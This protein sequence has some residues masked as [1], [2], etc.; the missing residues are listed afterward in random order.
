MNIS[1]PSPVSTTQRARHLTGPPT[2]YA[3]TAGVMG[4]RP[5][6]LSRI[7]ELSK[8]H[9]HVSNAESWLEI[10]WPREPISSVSGGSGEL[11]VGFCPCFGHGFS[12]LKKCTTICAINKL[13]Q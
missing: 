1:V 7:L 11:P 2:S 5:M 8:L 6:T 3:T 10:T 12:P 4:R 13:T 9:D